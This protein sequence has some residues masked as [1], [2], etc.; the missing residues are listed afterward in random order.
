MKIAG[1]DIGTTGCKCSVYDSEGTFI[2]E[3]YLEYE[4]L[5]C[6]SEH[7]INPQ[8][9]W[10]NV[11]LVLKEVAREVNDI[12]G[13][14]VTSFGEASVLMDEMDNPLMDALLFTDSNGQVEHEEFQKRF[15]DEKIFDTTGLVSGKM[16]SVIKW[17]W[18]ENNRPE[19][20][21]KCK[22]I[23]L[24]EDFIVYKLSGIRQ[25]DYSL[26][27]RTMA[28][29]VKNLKWSKEILE[30]T[31]VRE[32]Q[33]PKVV[34]SGS[35][36]GNMK[37]DMARELGFT[38]Q[39]LIISGCHDQ[40]AAA[41][42]TGVI[43]EGLSVD[44][45]GTIECITSVFDQSKI[46]DKKALIEGGYAVVPYL[47][48]KYVTYSFIYTGGA[49]LKWFRNNMANLEAKEARANGKNPF[50]EYN[51]L[52]NM[53]RPSPL[54]IVPHFAGSGTPIMDKDATG[55]MFGLTLDTKKEDIYQALM[56]GTSYE[57]RINLDILEKSGIRIEKIYATGGGA[58]SDKWLQI[59]SDVYNKEIYSL[60]SAQSGTLGCIMMVSVACGICD[61]LHS[62]RDKYIRVKQVFNPRK[63]MVDKYAIN[64][65]KYKKIY[66]II[67]NGGL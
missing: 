35:I 42:G 12:E 3:K 48:G 65:D 62:A 33:L 10:A 54:I 22:Y 26:A 59:K 16:Y 27:S 8:V 64:L 56:E 34:E 44:G 47:D 60:D 21:K 15:G 40:I 11:Q 55:M 52:L 28:L 24:F 20:F 18:I 38:N 9:V 45:I 66:S 23:H 14:G 17:K 32:E 49:L 25:I 13:I 57:M 4:T 39:P 58:N 29:D 67:E 36:A 61:N 31:N 53:D 46:T 5:I 1:L 30:W 37:S 41:I 43:D 19:V 2:V 50:D 6:D 63:D 51:D 7:S